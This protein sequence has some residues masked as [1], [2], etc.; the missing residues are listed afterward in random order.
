MIIE[1]IRFNKYISWF[2]ALFPLF[3]IFSMIGFNRISRDYEAYGNAF[4]DEEYRSNFEIGYVKLVELLNHFGQG[5]TTLV[6]LVG[7]I[8]LCVIAKF[9]KTNNHVNLVLFCYCV[10]PLVY[11]INQTRNTLMYLIVTLSLVYVIKEKPLKHFVALAIAYSIHSFALIYVPFYYLC[12]KD[13]KSFLKI[14]IIST[15]ALIVL[16]PLIVKI[17]MH[18]IPYKMAVYLD[19]KTRFG[20]IILYFYAFLDILTVWWIDKKINPRL[21]QEDK[22]KM[23]VL[24]R[25]VFFPIII[26]PFSP[27]FLTVI[28]LQ[29]NALLVKYI[30]CALAMGYMTVKEKLITVF[31]L[32]LS[33]AFYVFLLGDL[34]LFEYLNKNSVQYFLKNSIFYWL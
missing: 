3:F 9:L 31:L 22:R 25:F 17:L 33:L 23:E 11:D 28:R 5:I 8:F 2:L 6:F 12:K 15:L 19:N 24:Y 29:R 30:Y 16:S 18:V 7:V 26:L 10:F 13:R 34:Q 21:K 20:F 32:L 27:Y 4:W 14:M 1:L